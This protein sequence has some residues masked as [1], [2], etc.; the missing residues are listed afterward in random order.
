M[1][2]LLISLVKNER[3]ITTLGRAKE[4]RII[5]DKVVTLAK[6]NTSAS[7]TQLSK[8]IKS[9]RREVISKLLT[10]LAPRFSERNG[11]YTRVIK[12]GYR[13]G[14][15]AETAIIEYLDRP[16][17]VKKAVVPTEAKETDTVDAEVVE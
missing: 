13:R 10:D 1:T 11:G 7:I 17:A 15:G 12:Y 3:I 9:E 8:F 5:A 14:D 16:V 2:N 4:L 6:K